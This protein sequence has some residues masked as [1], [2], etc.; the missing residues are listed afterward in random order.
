MKTRLG[1]KPLAA[2][3]KTENKNSHNGVSDRWVFDQGVRV[4]PAFQL[5][6]YNG[7]ILTIG[8]VPTMKVSSDAESKEV[9][10]QF[11]QLQ[12]R[13]EFSDCGSVGLFT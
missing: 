6:S 8:E 3:Q 5:K 11:L 13:C 1:R 12:S 7:E 4:G 10:G 9:L 2:S